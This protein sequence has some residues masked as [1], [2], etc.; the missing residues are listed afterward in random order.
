MLLAIVRG[1]NEHCQPHPS[2][3]TN[4]PY[5]FELLLEQNFFYIYK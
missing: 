4:F 1:A 5:V 2:K 3:G